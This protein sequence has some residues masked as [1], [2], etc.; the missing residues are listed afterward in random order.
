M[1]AVIIACVVQQ[2]S[3]KTWGS[4]ALEVFS[5]NQILAGW[6]GI[7]GTCRHMWDISVRKKTYFQLQKKKEEEEEEGV[8]V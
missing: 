5:L 4:A 2:R 3:N 7:S 8:L 1:L 6:R